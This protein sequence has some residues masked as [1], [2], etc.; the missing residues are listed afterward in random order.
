MLQENGSSSRMMCQEQI[1]INQGQPVRG[2]LGPSSAAFKAKGKRQKA[3]SREP[4]SFA[5]ARSRDRPEEEKRYEKMDNLLLRRT[6]ADGKLHRTGW[7]AGS[8]GCSRRG[9]SSHCARGTCGGC[10]RGRAGGPGQYLDVPVPVTGT[11][12]SV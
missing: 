3:D 10:S 6:D 8:A 5:L 2:R 9:R 7:G 1:R 4:F 11:K 12:G